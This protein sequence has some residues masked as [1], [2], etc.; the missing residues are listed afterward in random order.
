MKMKET[1]MAVV[2]TATVG[3]FGLQQASARVHDEKPR[4]D[5]S[6][7]QFQKM[8]DATK[9]K[10]DKFHADTQ[11]LQK[12][13]VMKRAEESALIRSQSP[14]IEA[15]KK[16]AGELFDLRMTMMEKAKA[17]GLF[18]FKKPGDRDEKFTEKHVKIEKFF[19]DTKDLR[20]QMAVVRAEKHALMHSQ[21]PDP[22]A[23]AKV[24]GELFDLKYAIHEKAKTA[25]LPRDFHGM[26]NGR[27]GHRRHFSHDHD[28]GF[29]S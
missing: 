2:L 17:E 28:F 1:L 16:A 13:I 21:N 20:K 4:G 19:A 25:G 11:D 15:V 12:Q 18:A 23:V 22:L 9:A 3:I 8:D 24:A 29:M 10:I 5:C 26:G 27:M 7:Q 6:H 14:N